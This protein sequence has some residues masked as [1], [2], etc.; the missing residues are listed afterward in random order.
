MT[1]IDTTESEG[2][3]LQVLIDAAFANHLEIT[4]KCTV[5]PEGPGHSLGCSKEVHENLRGVLY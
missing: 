1:Q 5:L 4:C 2:P 3:V